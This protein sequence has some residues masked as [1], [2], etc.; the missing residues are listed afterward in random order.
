MRNI[1][2]SALV[3]LAFFPASAC[4]GKP[5]GAADKPGGSGDPSSEPGAPIVGGTMPD[6]G[7]VPGAPDSGP[8]ASSDAG[9]DA[10]PDASSDAGSVAHDAGP[11]VCAAS[12]LPTE[13][14]CVIDEAFAIFVSA[15]RGAPSGNGK[16]AT[17]F[18]SMQTAINAA[19][20]ASKR[21][22]ACAEPY[23][24]TVTFANGV[25]IFGY[26]DCAGGTWTTSTGHAH[27]NAPTSPAARATNIVTPTRIEGL[28]IIAPDATAFSGSSIA[29]IATGSP[30]LSFFHARLHAGAGKDGDSGTEGLRLLQTGTLNGTANTGVNECGGNVFACDVA[31]LGGA[32]GTSIC[33]GAPGHNGGQGGDGGFGGRWQNGLAGA[34]ELPTF[35]SPQPGT[36]TT[37]VGANFDGVHS[38]ASGGVGANGASGVSATGMGVFS[39]TGYVP[40]DGVPGLNGLPGAGGGGGAGH[41]PL[42]I[43]PNNNPDWYGVSGA[44]GG[45][46]GCPGLAGTAGKGGG[47]SIAILAIDSP[48]HVQSS[49]IETSHGGAG[50]WGTFGS[51]PTPGGFA[52]DDVAGPSFGPNPLGG[53]G[54]GGG[55]SGVSG[56][57]AGG[58]SIGVASHGV[59]PT[60]D[61]AP[62]VGPGGAGG[63]ADTSP[64]D[65]KTIPASAAGRSAMTYAF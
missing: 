46:G 16:R 37:A 26:F 65:G 52:G 10:S 42:G 51:A 49:I 45:A 50:G 59:A 62:V 64:I 63:P 38:G 23:A 36:A 15:S 5:S 7:G 19:K 47:A 13:D 27:I 8:D 54:G 14:A 9:S 40:A 6:A 25:S 2:L 28:E 30:G 12:L 17:P 39:A 61:A 20:A 24:E 22:Y 34:S 32:G 31:N 48:I 1:L 41:S 29:L 3:G 11:P 18:S 21:V 57:G 60:L 44:G 33:S 56:H 4:G 43:L 35:G 55:Q 53:N 58:P